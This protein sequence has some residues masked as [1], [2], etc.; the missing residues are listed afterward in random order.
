MKAYYIKAGKQTV[1]PVETDG[2]L[3]NLQALVGGLIEPIPNAPPD[4]HILVDEEGLI[5]EGKE[6][7][8]FTYGGGTYVGNGVILGLGEDGDYIAPSLVLEYFQRNI[9]FMSA[10]T[11]HFFKG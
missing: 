7:H 11:P 6:P 9:R 2:Q 8:L 3:A 1:E 4:H 10:T 5:K